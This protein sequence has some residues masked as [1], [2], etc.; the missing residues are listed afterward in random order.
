MAPRLPRLLTRTRPGWQA[1]PP[2]V[3]PRRSPQVVRVADAFLSP[4]ATGRLATVHRPDSWFRGAVYDHD[5]RLVRAS[6]KFL[7]DRRG[8]RVAADPDTIERTPAPVLA[9]TWLYGGT[10]ARVFG[11]F[12]VETLTTLWPTDLPRPQGLV[13]HSSFGNTRVDDWHRRF[14]ELAGWG[15]LP[16]HVVGTGEAVRVEDLVVPSRSVALHAWAHPEARQVW[17]TVASGFRGTGGT[18]RVYVSRT[19]LN[20]RRRKDGHRRPVRTTA[21]TDRQLDEVFTRHG[22]TVVRP[23]TLG[24][25]EQLRAVASASVIAGLSGSG[26]HHSAFIPSGGRVLELGDGRS[27]TRP[28]RMQV[29]ID[30]VS[31]HRR[32]F[33]P[34]DTSPTEL[35]R[36]MRRL[37]L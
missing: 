25:D 18:E 11:H 19:L 6:Q 12:L 36:V 9:G 3:R 17:D 23:E 29:A 20:E 30:A 2:P 22:F 35:V 21:E 13:F 15:D 26:L 31:E 14:I 5:D 16:V 24:V 10:W 8:P 1:V 32:C 34:G 28:V 27:S 7:G 37:G 33:V 4:V